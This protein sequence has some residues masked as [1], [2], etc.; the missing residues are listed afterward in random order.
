MQHG[1]CFREWS[2]RGFDELLYGLT[3]TFTPPPKTQT[4]DATEHSQICA[5]EGVIQYALRYN[6]MLHSLTETILIWQ[7]AKGL[8]L[9]DIGKEEKRG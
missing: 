6:T 1:I 9:Y 5:Y 2:T 4:F 7:I 8:Y 3:L